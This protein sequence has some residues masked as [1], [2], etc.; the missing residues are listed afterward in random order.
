ML[1][2]LTKQGF[3]DL[4]MVAN[5]LKFSQTPIEY[6]KPPPQL[7]EDH[8][9]IISQLPSDSDPANIADGG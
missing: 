3:A 2:S 6:L 4:P 5:P 1:F 7:N 8:A 9:D